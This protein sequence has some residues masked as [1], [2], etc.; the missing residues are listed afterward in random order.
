MIYHHLWLAVLSLFFITAIV[1]SEQQNSFNLLDNIRE[2]FKSLFKFDRNETSNED[3]DL[4]KQKRDYLQLEKPT[5]LEGSLVPFDENLE[6]PAFLRQVY[7][8]RQA[9]S[10]CTCSVPVGIFS[11]C[12][13]SCTSSEVICGQTC[14]K[15]TFFYGQ[16]LSLIYGTAY[17][18]TRVFTDD[19]PCKVLAVSCSASESIKSV[20]SEI[21]RSAAVVVAVGLAAIA[22]GV[23]VGVGV[24]ALVNNLDES[25][26]IP[27]A[28]PIEPNNFF[29]P[30]PTPEN[31]LEIPA[32]RSNFPD[33][34]CGSSSVQLQ[35]N[36]TAVAL[37]DFMKSLNKGNC[38]I[39][40]R[41]QNCS[42]PFQWVTLN[43]TTLQ[44]NG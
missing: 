1:N 32:R 35:S 37:S 2:L 38:T 41:R 33:D 26:S 11:Y 43:S 13:T 18:S 6:V 23:G 21:V 10:T 24:P 15:T 30:P 14:S 44:V 17:V 7:E 8:G 12:E 31:D 36:R 25:L 34:G 39:L 16:S 28:D 3:P 42:S 40:L 29:E 22:V 9:N 4:T 5:S 27:S 20:S 19:C